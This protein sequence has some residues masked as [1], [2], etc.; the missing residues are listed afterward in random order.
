MTNLSKVKKADTYFCCWCGNLHPKS[1]FV[2]PKL[3][4]SKAKK[5]FNKIIKSINQIKEG[6]K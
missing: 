5:M 2:C 1:K 6:K 3:E 4:T